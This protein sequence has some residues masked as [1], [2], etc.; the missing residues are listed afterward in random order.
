MGCEMSFRSVLLRG[1]ERGL[2][3]MGERDIVFVGEYLRE[4]P[5]MLR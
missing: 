2:V 4:R 1:C 3:V 5:V